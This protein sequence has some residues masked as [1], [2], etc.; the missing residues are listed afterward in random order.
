MTNAEVWGSCD[1]RALGLKDSTL[2]NPPPTSFFLFSFSFLVAT[3]PTPPFLSL[4][5]NEEMLSYPR[6]Q[7]RARRTELG[8]SAAGRGGEGRDPPRP[9]PE[10]D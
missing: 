5:P 4:Q 1:V 3:P 7:E 8:A 6:A 2:A 9:G 10:S